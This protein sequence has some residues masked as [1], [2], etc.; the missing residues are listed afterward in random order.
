MDTGSKS[1]KLK[2]EI[3]SVKKTSSNL[4]AQAF[5]SDVGSMKFNSYVCSC[6][7]QVAMKTLLWKNLQRGALKN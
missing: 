2:T 7:G 6:V 1:K 3:P 5:G 4:V